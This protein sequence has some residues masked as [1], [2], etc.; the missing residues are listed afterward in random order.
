LHT[1]FKY[2]DGFPVT[3]ARVYESKKFIFF[4][5]IYKFIPCSLT[6]S[7][8]ENFPV[9][10]WPLIGPFPFF[11]MTRNERILSETEKL[12]FRVQIKGPVKLHP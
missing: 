9:E 12:N 3:Y 5:D 7:W 10:M 2:R 6:L 11:R 4:A 1:L 8:T